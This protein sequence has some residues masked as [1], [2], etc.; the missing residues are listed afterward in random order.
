M[1]R[2]S[3]V[4]LKNPLYVKYHDEEWSVP[5]HDDQKLFE[6]IV[7]ESA[8]AGLS[9]ETILNR[10]AGYREAFD[11][12]NPVKIA[13]YTEVVVVKLM[14]DERIIRNKLKIVATIANAKQFLAIQKEFGSFAK[15]LWKWKNKERTP[16]LRNTKDTI[17]YDNVAIL[18]SRD[19]KQRGFKFFGPIICYAYMQ[20]VG[21]VNDHS[22]KCFKY[23]K[24]S[25]G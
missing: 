8:Q 20:A 18:L 9:W 3:W 25:V 2:C 13:Q 11:N 15:Y 6:F 4:N 10:R 5:L 23:K 22:K 21:M 24:P 14:K 19:L 12:F 1:N 7:L 16:I 17:I